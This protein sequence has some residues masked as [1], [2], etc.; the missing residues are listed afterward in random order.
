VRA[1]ADAAGQQLSPA[2]LSAIVFEVDRLHHGTPSGIDNS[3]ICYEQPVYFVRGHPP[4]ILS[5]GKPFLLAIADSGIASP[6]KATVADVRQTWEREPARF[7]GVLD[8]I[9]SIVEE[10]RAAVEDG[11]P[12]ALGPLMN[13][14]HELL[15]EI[16][17]SSPE[18]EALATAARRAGAGGAK[19][20]GGGRGG[21]LIAL[22]TDATA[23]PVS[24]A[25]KAAGAVNVIVTAVGEGASQP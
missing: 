8:H 19:L 15:C 4:Q 23:D 3:V 6:T 21:N 10:A 20:S 22:V 5:V 11:R 12:E 25:L 9:A 16:G 17:V 2:D 13:D 14:N 7:Q 1:L 24:T 18:L